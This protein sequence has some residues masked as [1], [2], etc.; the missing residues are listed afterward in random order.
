M[1]R[2]NLLTLPT[3]GSFKPI[4]QLNWLPT[5]LPGIVAV[6]IILTSGVF[7]MQ[8]YQ[9]TKMPEIKSVAWFMANQKEALA[10]NKE[11][12]DN[13]QLKA[14]PNCVYSLQALEL[15]HKGPNS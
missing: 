5:N 9:E 15:T 8:K 1:K 7:A 12:Y 13:P 4:V 3:V 6:G 14:T 10:T 11:C 2:S